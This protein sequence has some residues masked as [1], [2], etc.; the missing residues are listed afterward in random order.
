MA[1]QVP[2]VWYTS[3][4]GGGPHHTR[5]FHASAQEPC[6]PETA[7]ARVLGSTSLVPLMGSNAVLP[8][9]RLLV[10]LSVD[11][12]GSNDFVK[13]V[14]SSLFVHSISRNGSDCVSCASLIF[15]HRVFDPH[16][17]PVLLSLPLSVS[18]RQRP[19]PLH[20]SASPSSTPLPPSCPWPSPCV[21]GAGAPDPPR[22]LHRHP[23]THA[24]HRRSHRRR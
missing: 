17:F 21:A 8:L 18:L 23:G 6:E 15:L 22:Y 13:K 4:D 19:R 16:T 24:R 14:I 20:Q 1:Q 12:N 3:V 10:A 9:S 2:R 11:E 7:I 5:V